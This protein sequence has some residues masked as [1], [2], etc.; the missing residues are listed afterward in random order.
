MN[1]AQRKQRRPEAR[2]ADLGSCRALSHVTGLGVV[3][4][5]LDEVSELIEL[6]GVDLTGE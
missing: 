6:V 4:G 5:Q 2:N 3:L 1:L